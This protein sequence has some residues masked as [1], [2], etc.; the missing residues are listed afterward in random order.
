MSALEE[1]SQKN[2]EN[3]LDNSIVNNIYNN[4]ND[5]S[6]LQNE[7]FTSKSSNPINIL[8][9]NYINHLNNLGIGNNNNNMNI[10]NQNINVNNILPNILQQ[11][12]NNNQFNQ[13]NSMNPMNQTNN[14][15][16]ILGNQNPLNISNQFNFNN[17]NPTLQNDILFKLTYTFIGK[18]GWIVYS[19]DGNTVNNYTSLELFKFFTEK[20][21]GN[22]V[23]LDDYV[24][25]NNQNGER[26]RGGGLYLSMLNI[27]PL[28]YQIMAEELNNQKNMYAKM[29]SNNLNNNVGTGNFNLNNL[30][31]NLNLNNLN[32]FNV[33]N[34]GNN[35]ITDIPGNNNFN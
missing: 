22:S 2:S 14:L 35:N 26:Y 6:Q 11:Q 9:N 23:R 25:G 19:Q 5:Y 29:M 3:F 24:I 17:I 8:N 20:I 28:A 33:N 7:S 12:M 16:N 13:M 31:N 27:L 10:N 30:N 32:N 15:F 21:V 34:F 18:K 1:L 4:M